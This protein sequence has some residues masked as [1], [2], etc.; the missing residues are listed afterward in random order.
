MWGMAAPRRLSFIALALLTACSGAASSDLFDPTSDPAASQPPPGEAD[1]GSP[2][3]GSTSSTSSSGAPG[4]KDPGDPP[5]PDPTDPTDPP[6]PSDPPACAV[7]SEPNNGFASA[8]AFDGCITG[9]LKPRDVDYLSTIAP[10][11][12]T[13]IAIKHSETG[14]TV[15][16]RVFVDGVAYPVFTGEPPD[17]IPAKPNEKYV[18]QVQPAGT[19]TKDRTYELEVSFQ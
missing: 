12:V 4:T 15:A 11:G 8:N 19:S 7:E 13:S 9:T 14:G 6:D 5:P 18:F 1:P 2:S 10:A 16:Y 17:S 3:G